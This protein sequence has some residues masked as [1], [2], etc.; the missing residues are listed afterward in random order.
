M[1]AK[2]A[3][4]MTEDT[5]TGSTCHR[6]FRRPSDTI[7]RIARMTSA[8]RLGAARSPTTGQSAQGWDRQQPA[9]W[10]RRCGRAEDST[11][12][13]QHSTQA[14]I[15]HASGNGRPNWIGVEPFAEPTSARGLHS[16]L[17]S[18][19]LAWKPNNRTPSFRWPAAHNNSPPT[20]TTDRSDWPSGSQQSRSWRTHQRA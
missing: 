13:A 17:S 20:S 4:Q 18:R 19:G 15:Q 6:A 14:A 7:A 3:D 11:R 16:R 9:R 10:K 1:R 8:V 12:P 5:D 2:G